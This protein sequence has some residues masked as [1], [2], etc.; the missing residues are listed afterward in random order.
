[1]QAYRALTLASLA[2]AACSA[3]ADE[4]AFL[5]APDIHGDRV[6]FTREGDL[7]LGDLGNGQ[8]RRLTR[9]AG[10]ETRARFS[11]DGSKIAFQGQYDGGGSQVYVMP[12]EGGIPQRVTNRI[13]AAIIEDW[14]PDGRK[15]LCRGPGPEFVSQ[16]FMVP[17]AGGPEEPLPIERLGMGQMGP[18]GR[19]AFCRYADISGGAWFRY[20]GGSR[21][22]I[23]VGDLT[24]LSFRKVF[25]SK[26]QAQ[27]PQWIG[28]R[29]F[30]VHENDATWTVNS[31]AGSGGGAKR[32]TSPSSDVVYDLQ[33]DGKR[34]IY[35][36]G[37]GLEVY[38]PAA[39]QTLPVKL[40][41][42][43]D[44]IHMR[45]MRVDVAPGVESYSITPT[46]KRIMVESR[47]Q[48]INVPAKEGEVRVWKAMPGVR[49]QKPEMSPDG[50]KVAYVSDETR[51]QQVY[52]ADA[53][54][55]NAKAVTKDGERQIA[56][57]QWSPDSQWL[58]VGDSESR[59]RLVKADGSE[60]FEVA[61]A[62]RS[63]VPLTHRFS[64]DSKWLVY[65]EEK[66]WTWQQVN[67]ISMIEIGTK[68][69]HQVTSGR[70]RDD[71][72]SFSSDGKYLVYASYRSLPFTADNILSQLNSA[73]AAMLVLVPLA[74]TTPSPFRPRNEEEGV[75]PEKPSEDKTLKIDFDGI[76]DRL[77]M[78]PGVSAE[79]TQ[80]E[81]VGDR[82]IYAAGSAINFYDVTP[83]AG[84]TI[85]PGGFFQ[86]SADGKSLMISG[87]RV[88]PIAGKDL[89]AAA[90]A[91]SYQGFK[92]DVNPAKEWEQ[93]FWDAWR[94]CRDYFYVR[95]MHGV[96]WKAVG[97]KYAKL[98]P[99]VRAR[100]ELT[101]LIRWM[102]AEL[103]VGHSFRV[104]PQI[105]VAPPASTPAY[106][107][108]ETKAD[109]GFH[110]ITHLY[111]GDG[112]MTGSPL[113]EPGHGVGVG[114]Y[115]VSVNGQPATATMDWREL[116]RDRAGQIVSLGVNTRASAEGAKTIYVRPHSAAVERSLWERDTVK[117]R[118][119]VV[120][121]RSGGKVGYIYLGGMVDPDMEEFM[122]QYLGQLDK[123]ALIVDIRENNGGYISAILVNLLKKETYLRRSERN[124]QEAGSRYHDAFEGH[125]CMLINE[126]SYSDGEGGPT[127]WRYAKLGPLI[128]KRTYGALV[129][130]APAWPLVDGGAI[131]VPRYGNYREDTGWV[132]EGPGVAPDIEVENDPNLWAKGTDA[133]LERAIKEM[134]DRIAKKPIKR[135]V[136]PPDPT[137][138]KTRG[139]GGN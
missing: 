86:V 125:L 42:N 64:P 134:M 135:P 139:G 62:R 105:F 119:L 111:D 95:N 44:R 102:Q 69:R 65:V 94:L 136:Q 68:T 56:T 96:D 92:L 30:F 37:N 4:G 106:L 16:P 83:R 3:I 117:K 87:P 22:D 31:V 113:L 114:S 48:I 36:R 43:S 12:T 61:R 116:L 127:N 81:M 50:K 58:A 78:V 15:L 60:D 75:T 76:K 97:D 66:P 32:H 51:E 115:I 10:I 17:A 133:Q 53:D 49:L 11:P 52:V 24:T 103:S 40:T 132:V 67:V 21:N 8:A 85:T 73:P 2:F 84:G 137:W 38:D 19:L 77:I 5:L 129:G 57:L 26:T 138:G 131:Q 100:N 124:S 107:G 41:L 23:W 88:V 99:H 104:D 54:G 121:Q 14:T 33:S 110:R 63:M 126:D 46:G 98:L 18:D 82:I 55:S 122:L 91:V 120:D 109:G 93:I 112:M 79:I 118:R 108:I 130:S 70:F 101:E 59:I 27:F 39:N 123:E 25:E 1:M 71:Y 6:V 90:G 9:H 20:Q 13:N 89:P 72:P 80:V 47:G 74:K 29:V 28:D 35:V 128:G 34:L 7:W 45:E